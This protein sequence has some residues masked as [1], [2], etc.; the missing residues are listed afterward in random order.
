VLFYSRHGPCSVTVDT[1]RVLLQWTR[2]V[3]CYSGHGP[4]SV[5]VDTDRVLFGAELICFRGSCNSQWLNVIPNELLRSI[6]W[7][8]GP[9]ANWTGH[10]L[11]R[12]CLLQCVR[13][14]AVHLGYGT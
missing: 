5:T 13:K 8:E 11:L 3:V 2:T 7:S 14:V 12:T 10:I 9:E 4:C 6:A 1:D